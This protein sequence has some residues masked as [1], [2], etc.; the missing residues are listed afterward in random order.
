MA[1][2]V[3]GAISL[4]S[5]SFIFLAF[6][7]E[8]HNSVIFIGRK[9]VLIWGSSVPL[10]VLFIS[11]SIAFGMAIHGLHWAVLGFLENYYAEG[12]K[13]K[14]VYDTYWH[15]LRIVIQILLGP[16]KI[17]CEILQFLF[18]GKNLTE[19]AIDENITKIS[20]DK[21]HAFQFLQDFYLNFA[22]FYAHTSYALTVS[23]LNFLIFC[24]ICSF[25]LERVGILILIYLIAG[26]FFVIARIQIASLFTGENNL[27]SP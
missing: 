22:Q 6:H 18:E 14:K 2:F 11:L 25:N 24:F 12:D 20:Q 4:D 10:G 7:G 1:Q 16:I 17:V 21:E 27:K 5:F 8:F 26:Y 9:T 19:I 15:N 3:P 13:L 23:F